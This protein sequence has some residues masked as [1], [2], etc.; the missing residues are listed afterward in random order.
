MKPPPPMPE[1]CGSTTF[2]ASKVAI[3]ASAAVPPCRNIDAPAAAARGSAALTMPPV[4]AAMAGVCWVAQAPSASA[5]KRVQIRPGIAEGLAASH[6]LGNARHPIAAEPLGETVGD[7][8]G[9]PRP[10]IDH[11]RIELDEAGAGKDPLPRIVGIFDPAHGNQR[12][13][14]ARRGS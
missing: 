8:P 1:L 11:R 7:P 2:S 13:A 10:F 3:A 4:V 9:N 5:A 14:A 6:R 12:N